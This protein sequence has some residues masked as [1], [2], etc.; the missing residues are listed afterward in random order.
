MRNQYH[1]EKQRILQFHGKCYRGINWVDS[2]KGR[3]PTAKVTHYG[4]SSFAHIK[5]TPP[6]NLWFIAHYWCTQSKH[7]RQSII[8]IINPG[9]SACRVEPLCHQL[10]DPG[11]CNAIIIMIDPNLLL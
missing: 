2:K 4:R 3:A 6:T 9:E 1:L 8:I 11:A 10:G 7:F 5:H